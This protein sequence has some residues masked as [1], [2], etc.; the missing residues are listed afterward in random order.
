MSE[1]TPGPWIDEDARRTHLRASMG[2]AVATVAPKT[3]ANA[4]ILAA[5]PDAR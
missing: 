3:D 2:Y 5:A 1:H 4:R